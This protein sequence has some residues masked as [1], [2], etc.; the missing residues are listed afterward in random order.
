[1]KINTSLKEVDGYHNYLTQAVSKLNS[2]LKEARKIRKCRASVI[3][4]KGLCN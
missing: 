3:S 1:M 2:L 4:R